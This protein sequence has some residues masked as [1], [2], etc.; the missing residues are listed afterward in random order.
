MYIISPF[1]QVK[2]SVSGL[3]LKSP[4]MDSAVT[5]CRSIQQRVMHNLFASYLLKSV[6]LYLYVCP[7]V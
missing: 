6:C 7:S 3:K 2:E 1:G 4:A 5:I